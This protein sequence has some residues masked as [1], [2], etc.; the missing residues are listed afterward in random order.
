MENIDY[1]LDT[2]LEKLESKYRELERDILELQNQ[3]L[4]L[5]E[6]QRKFQKANEKGNFSGLP[7]LPALTREEEEAFREV[8]CPGSMDGTINPEPNYY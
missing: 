7:G 6:L 3:L 1:F 2:G 8:S 5:Q 4:T